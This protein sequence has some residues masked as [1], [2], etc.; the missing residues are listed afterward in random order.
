[1]DVYMAACLVHIYTCS[2]LYWVYIIEQPAGVN[3]ST[4]RDLLS[5]DS[6]RDLD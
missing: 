1:M 2:M 6:C 4:C 3:L 5:A